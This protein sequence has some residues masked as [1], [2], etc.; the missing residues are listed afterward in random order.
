MPRPP[1]EII[2]LTI[3]AQ[4]QR[5][6]L[7]TERYE[8]LIS[9][10]RRYNTTLTHKSISYDRRSCYDNERRAKK[11]KITHPLIMPSLIPWIIGDVLRTTQEARSGGHTVTIMC[12]YVTSQEQIETAAI[13]KLTRRLLRTHA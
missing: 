3:E 9:F 1:V 4:S 8:P 13:A 5:F 12:A 6:P 11:D 7:L 10:T 2:E